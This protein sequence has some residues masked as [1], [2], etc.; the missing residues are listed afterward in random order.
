MLFLAATAASQ[1]KTGQL[2]GLYIC[3]SLKQSRPLSPRQIRL[4]HLNI[5]SPLQ[6]QVPLSPRHDSCHVSNMCFLLQLVLS[7][8][9]RQEAG[10]AERQGRECTQR[11]SDYSTS[12]SAWC[13]NHSNQYGGQGYGH[14][15]GGE[16]QG[17][18]TAGAHEAVCPLLHLRSVGWPLR[19]GPLVH[20]RNMASQAVCQFP[21]SV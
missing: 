10:T 12:R 15:A 1:S 18:G 3:F 20:L 13:G 5:F 8:C 19:V 4:P 2:L 7:D 17:P 6:L 21:S 14:C 9:S 16:P 11:G